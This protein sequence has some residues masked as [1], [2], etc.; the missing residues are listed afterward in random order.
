MPIDPKV[1]EQFRAPGGSKFKLSDYDSAWLPPQAKDMKKAQMKEFASEL[2]AENVTDLAT[3]QDRLYASHNYSVLLVFQ[4]MDAAGKDGTIKHVMSGINPQG[5]Q[6]FSFKAPS[7]EELDHD[8]LWRTTKSMPERGRIGIFNRSYYEE[9]LVVKVNPRFLDA[10]N[11]PEAEPTKKF[12]N[13]RYESINDFERHMTRN[14]TVILKFY[15][16]LSQTEQRR[17]FLDRIDDPAKNWKFSSADLTESLRWDEYMAAYQDAI[18]ATST[19]IAPWWIIPADRKF[20]ARSLVS[21]IVRQTL[22]GLDLQY[23][24]LPELEQARLADARA[25]LVAL[26]EGS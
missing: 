25:Q 20:I 8:F 1:L 9:V 21:G 14:G 2:L 7:K 11:L 12:W 26:Q 3:L 17:R 4:A 16:N 10:Q 22:E 15:L 19:D 23:P 6:V 13:D 24:V 18:R 5:C